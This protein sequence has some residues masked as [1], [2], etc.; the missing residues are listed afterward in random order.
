MSRQKL[1]NQRHIQ[2][3]GQKEGKFCAKA[4]LDFFCSY[5]SNFSTPVQLEFQTGGG[6]DF[7]TG[8]QMINPLT[9]VP[10]VMVQVNLFFTPK[11]LREQGGGERA[12]IL[13][14]VL[15]KLFNNF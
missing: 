3:L 9:N 7:F 12:A 15:F 8:T 6:D 1:H 10:G 5:R 13:Q 4:A 11:S 2:D 14:N